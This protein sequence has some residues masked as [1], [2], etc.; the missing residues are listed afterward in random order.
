MI[1]FLVEILGKYT[2]EGFSL[3]LTFL[4]SMFA[5][6]LFCGN[7]RKREHFAVRAP[8][9]VL[10]GVV[11]CYLLAILNTEAASLPVRVICYL[12]ITAYDLFF[13][14]FCWDDAPE[15]LLIAF[16]C[17]TA[18]YQIG[19]KLYPLLQNLRGI[20]DKATI[21]LSRNSAAGLT[22]WD[23]LLFILLR[24]GVY[25][26]L[27]WLFHPKSRLAG[28]KRTRRNTVFISAVTVGIVTVLVCFARVH[29]AE[30][31]AM[32]I[33]VKIFTIAFAL[34]ILMLARGIFTEG[35][36]ERQIS[37]LHQLWRQ[38]KAQF[39]SVKANMDVINMKCHDLK[40]ILGKIEGKLTESE[41]DSLREAIEFYDSNIKTGNEVLDVVL[42]EKA[43][44]CQKN[45]ISFSCMA[46]GRQFDFL[47]PV[48]TYSLF[49]NI[50]DNAIEA[51]NKLPDKD[52][53]VI[54][55]TCGERDGEVVIEESNYFGGSLVI[56]DGLPATGKQ[57][58][59]RHGFG[60][61]SIKYIA[62]QYGGRLDIRTEADMFF[63]TVTF[64]AGAIR[65]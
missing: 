22:G 42:C 55:L 41:V 62:E 50:I 39:E 40:H 25:F 23:W 36:K 31:M 34:L 6:S 26:L 64:P 12:A 28:D 15:E 13:L 53:K 29:E 24:V 65:H 11:L 32:N 5:I 58:A 20:D 38:D 52:N 37:V 19:N 49:G 35:E 61:K 45:D 44:T 16:S 46:D 8:I 1:D 33:V 51:V 30:S 56:E 63:L 57:D 60:T 27:A 14:L 18:A 3:I 48:Q 43:M 2:F 59:S 21:S 47:T 54:A 7:I 9:A 4:E 10:E 17:G